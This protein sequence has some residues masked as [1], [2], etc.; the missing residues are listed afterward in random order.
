[1]KKLWNHTFM[2]F[3]ISYA[4][5]L[6]LPLLVLGGVVN[7]YFANYY[8]DESLSKNLNIPKQI[9]TAVD[10][11]VT[12]MDSFSNQIGIDSRF[13]TRNLNRDFGA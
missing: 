11:Q 3:L 13:R 6:F 10:M 8:I 9:Q 1:M 7:F 5:V 12:Q 2:Q 4:L